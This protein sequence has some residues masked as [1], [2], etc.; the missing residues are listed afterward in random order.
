M[1]HKKRVDPIVASALLAVVV[2]GITDLA[3][4][5][6]RLTSLH[7]VVEVI[8]VVLS[9]GLAVYLWSGWLETELSL[10]RMYT[11]IRL[12]RVAEPRFRN[13]VRPSVIR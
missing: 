5:G 4:D 8:M 10:A 1:M 6:L 9:L 12:S 3:L 13:V 2:V 11:R 7:L